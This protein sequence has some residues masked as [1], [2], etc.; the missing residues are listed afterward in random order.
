MNQFLILGLIVFVYLFRAFFLKLKGHSVGY[1]LIS[2]FI[3]CV[4]FEVAKAL[5]IPVANMFAGSLGSTYYFTVVLALCVFLTPYS[6]WRNIDFSIKYYDWV[7]IIIF[8]ILISLLNPF[9]VIAR[10]TL[11]FGIFFLSHILLFKM[12]FSMLDRKDILLG[13]FDGLMF[14]SIVQLILAICYP[15]LGISA[16]TTLIH[17]TAGE[18]A[19]RHGS[20]RVGA[21]GTFLHPGNLAL[22]TIISSSF[23]YGSFL[24]SYRKRICL[25]VLAGNA[26]TLL[27][28]NSR[29]SYITFIIV[30]GVI[31]FVH[32]NAQKRLF[33]FLNIIKYVLPVAIA[34][35]WLVYFS[36]LSDSFLKGDTS[37]QY[38]NRL[39]HY[40]MAFSIFD[41]SPYMGVG[42]NAHLG[43][44]SKNFYLAEIFTL[45]DFFTEN[46]IHNVHLIVLS[47]VGLVG[48]IL[49]IGFL[50][51]RL[52]NARLHIASGRNQIFSLT[53][54][55]LVVAY[56][57]YG[58][59]GWAP[60]SNGIIP[61]F[62]FI[63]YF[64]I[65][66]SQEHS[67]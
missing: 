32:N 58:M 27:L 8:F 43:F 33:S 30:L 52:T 59:T 38:E 4:P 45:D 60:F 2:F 29:T 40:Y 46:P 18:A 47:E 23:F 5:T 64:S 50:I 28:T 37:E 61:Y 1:L 14:L 16:V 65:K 24:N 19:T 62:L 53:T 51:K 15:V 7:S 35:V 41:V 25:G 54:I 12:L 20:N 9:N 63:I 48:F 26:V 36:P 6:N 55:G 31:Y 49:W 22:F 34:L 56:F 39:L 21:V 44:L 3:F 13:L 67:D 57:I 42:L 66:L 17:N 11:V 10:G